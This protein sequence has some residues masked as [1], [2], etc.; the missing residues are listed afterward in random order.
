MAVLSN[1]TSMRMKRRGFPGSR[2][3]G[4]LAGAPDPKILER[5]WV[6]NGEDT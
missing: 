2:K 6:T 4:P 3:R 5:Y 1:I